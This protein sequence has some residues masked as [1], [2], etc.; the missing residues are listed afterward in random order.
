[1]QKLKYN[2]LQFL[3]TFS[4]PVR[5]FSELLCMTE[6][7]FLCAIHRFIYV[8]RWRFETRKT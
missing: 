3:F 7:H 2:F 1:M 6:K 8:T 5:H 4:Y